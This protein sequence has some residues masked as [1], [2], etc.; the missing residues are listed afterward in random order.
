MDPERTRPHL[1]P[2]EDESRRTGRAKVISAGK[3]MMLTVARMLL[4]LEGHGTKGTKRIINLLGRG[5]Y[6]PK[7]SFHLP[8]KPS[9]EHDCTIPRIALRSGILS[10]SFTAN[11][12]PCL[13]CSPDP[14]CVSDERGTSDCCRYSGSMASSLVTLG[15]KSVASS[16][17]LE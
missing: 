10:S 11:K 1:K 17:I 6:P 5:Q 2:G 4:F 16:V 9:H 15:L 3:R 7:F 13:R 12:V 8:H 14:E